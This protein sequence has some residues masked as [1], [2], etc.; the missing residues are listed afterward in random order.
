MFMKNKNKNK[1]ITIVWVLCARVTVAGAGS[2]KGLCLSYDDLP[3]HVT[4]AQFHEFVKATG[5]MTVAECK[6]KKEWLSAGF[7]E[8]DLVSRTAV[9]ITPK[10]QTKTFCRTGSHWRKSEGLA[11]DIKQR[12]NHPVLNITKSR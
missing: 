9:F 3:E 1:A 4:N 6:P 5:Y 8:E 7:S 10:I 2:D 11:R 12:M